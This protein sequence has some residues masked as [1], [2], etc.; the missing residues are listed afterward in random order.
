[1]QKHQGAATQGKL[2]LCHR[3]KDLCAAADNVQQKTA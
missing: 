1:M 3:L 2:A